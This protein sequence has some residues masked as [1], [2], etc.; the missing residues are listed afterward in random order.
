MEEKLPYTDKQPPVKRPDLLTV[1]CVLTFIGSGLAVFSNLLIYLT[2]DEM[3][4]MIE[5]YEIEIPGFYMMMSGGKKFFIAGFIL[6]SFSC[7]GALQMWKLK[8]LGFHLYTGAQILILLLPVVMI[9]SY[10]FS[11]FSLLFT[12]IFVIGYAV[13]YKYMS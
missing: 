10:Q 7:Y 6:Y 5:E 13:N 2:Y 4:K 8:K 1:L 3:L 12:A 11:I 9:S